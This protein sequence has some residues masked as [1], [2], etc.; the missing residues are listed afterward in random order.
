MDSLIRYGFDDVYE[1]LKW[2]DKVTAL[3][4][5][6]SLK[7]Q[8]VQKLLDKVACDFLYQEYEELASQFTVYSLL[9]LMSIFHQMTYQR[10]EL[11][12]KFE[13]LFG[14]LYDASR[15]EMLKGN[16]TEVGHALISKD[17]VFVLLRI[18]TE[19]K[20]INA[21]IWE[22][23]QADIEALLLN[24]SFD[25]KELTSI[26]DC[27]YKTSSFHSQHIQKIAEY[28]IKRN[29][30]ATDFSRELNAN[31]CLR[32]FRGLFIMESIPTS[33][34]KFRPIFALYDELVSEILFSKLS[35]SSWLTVMETCRHSKEGLG[36]LLQKSKE[37]FKKTYD[38]QELFSTE[39]VESSSLGE[40]GSQADKR[41]SRSK[42]PKSVLLSKQ[43]N[44]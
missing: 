33:G 29:Y 1:K 10:Q 8:Y 25:L 3:E 30:R 11:W 18:L 7:P 27:Y 37:H 39:S 32:F 31:E 20:L 12:V 38:T 15:K 2:L 14:V 42:R 16:N 4:I 40:G 22:L 21:Q 23:L 24:D 19:R 35:V 36:R 41:S 34:M 13:Q 5:A 26:L 6:C 9:Q 43:K 17:H 44:E 28:I